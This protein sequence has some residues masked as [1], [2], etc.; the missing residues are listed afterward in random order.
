MKLEILECRPIHARHAIGVEVEVLEVGHVLEQGGRDEGDA[1]ALQLNVV[2]VEQLVE[3]AITEGG[4]LVVVQLQ[5]LQR[6]HLVKQPLLQGSQPV[7]RGPEGQQVSDAAKESVGEGGEAVVVKAE[8]LETLHGAQHPRRQGVD[9]R[10]KC[11]PVVRQ[12]A[13]AVL[14]KGQ[15]LQVLH[16]GQGGKGRGLKKV[17]GQIEHDKAETTQ[18]VRVQ[19]AHSPY[20]RRVPWSSRLKEQQS[21]RMI[22][23]CA[24]HSEFPTVGL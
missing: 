23:F 7:A 21:N 22:L 24:R 8:V 1:V 12:P 6:A 18:R 2:D 15:R 14:V 17:V 4:D 16:L 13:D 19:D 5:R 10:G 11:R 9:P 3:A 20:C